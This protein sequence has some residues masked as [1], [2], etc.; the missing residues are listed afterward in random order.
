MCDVVHWCCSRGNGGCTV[1]A[2][3]GISSFP[4]SHT[5]CCVE[6][7]SQDSPVGS[8]L[9]VS[10]WPAASQMYSPASFFSS[11]SI[12][13]RRV[14]PAV[15]ILNFLEEISSLP[16]LYHFTSVASSATSQLRVALSVRTAFTSFWTCSWFI[17][18]GF[19]S[20]CRKG[21]KYWLRD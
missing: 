16:S 21:R 17:N 15:S 3:Q 1:A 13:R 8:N 18:A 6:P 10:F 14:L 2:G 12:T 5:D 9:N 7:Q 4:L 19:G 20:E 11:C